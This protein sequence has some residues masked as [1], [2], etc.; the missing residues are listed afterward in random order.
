MRAM[1]FMDTTRGMRSKTK[2]GMLS[3]V[4]TVYQLLHLEVYSTSTTFLVRVPA[5]GADSF[6]FSARCPGN[7]EML[8]AVNHTT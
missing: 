6:I 2:Q 1:A 4:C 3:D 5:L 7:C 8:K